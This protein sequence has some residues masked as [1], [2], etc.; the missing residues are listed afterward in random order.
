MRLYTVCFCL[1]LAVCLSGCSRD[2]WLHGKWIFDREFTEAKMTKEP[3]PAKKDSIISAL[4]SS[5]KGLVTSQL[6]SHLDGTK[7]TITSKEIIVTD[8]NGSGK[9]Y[10]YEVI[11]RPSDGAVQVKTSDGAVE[12][13]HR[14]G[15][16][17]GMGELYFKRLEK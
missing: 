9:A 11:D 8:A 2:S 17:I 16:H 12:T 1:L 15:D 10:T 7:L 5:L 13:Y 6:T 14:E 3:P 4:T